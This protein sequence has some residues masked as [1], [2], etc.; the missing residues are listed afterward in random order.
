MTEVEGFENLSINDQHFTDVLSLYLDD[1]EFLIEFGYK[2]G[3]IIDS[4]YFKTSKQR[5][6]KYPH[7]NFKEQE[8]GLKEEVEEQSFST[9]F[10][11]SQL[12]FSK[13]LSEI[14]NEKQLKALKE[15]KAGLLFGAKF[16]TQGPKGT[17]SI[18]AE[19]NNKQNKN[20]FTK[21]L[22]HITISTSEWKQFLFTYQEKNENID[23]VTFTIGA[24]DGVMWAGQFGPRISGIFIRYLPVQT[25]NEKQLFQYSVEY[26]NKIMD[27]NQE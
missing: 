19:I 20:L 10:F 3:L 24:K 21:Q 15:A 6:L 5:T 23:N 22:N 1:D 12:I 26:E 17:I 4:L 18:K 2:N 8:K 14:L 25:E 27:L 9:S 16:R 7:Q 13:K 11:E